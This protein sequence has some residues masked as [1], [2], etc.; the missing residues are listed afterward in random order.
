[1]FQEKCTN[2]EQALESANNVSSAEI[3]ALKR[4][5][6][7]ANE[8]NENLNKSY[9]ELKREHESII[10][11]KESEFERIRVEM[12]KKL[13]E[14]DK[15]RVDLEAKVSELNRQIAQLKNELKEKTIELEETEKRLN[16]LIE[17]QNDSDQSISKLTT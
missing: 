12:T 4:E 6:T 9:E 7:L 17:I 8:K 10:F 1:M 15:A 5:I 3:R 16:D 2:L 13:K 11:A 14:S